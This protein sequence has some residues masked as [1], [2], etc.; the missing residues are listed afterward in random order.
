MINLDNVDYF[1]GMI[2]Q[3]TGKHGTVFTMNN[4]R[5]LQITCPV[6]KVISAINNASIINGV[7]PNVIKLEYG[8]ESLSH[9]GFQDLDIWTEDQMRDWII[10]HADMGKFIT[11]DS[12]A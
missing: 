1:K 10:D 5:C 12:I 8:D 6:D 2:H 11:G 3:P 4:G 7:N 9:P